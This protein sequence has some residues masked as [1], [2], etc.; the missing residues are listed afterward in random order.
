MTCASD[1]RVRLRQGMFMTET[2]GH[3]EAIHQP[4]AVV[5][6]VGA[7]RGLGAALW[8]AAAGWLS[9]HT[10]FRRM[11]PSNR[12]SCSTPVPGLSAAI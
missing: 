5:V 9:S 7:E 4:T 1:H 2:M 10:E 11:S 6:G 3:D 12:S 8:F